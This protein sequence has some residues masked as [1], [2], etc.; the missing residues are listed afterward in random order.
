MSCLIVQADFTLLFE[1]DS[2]KFEEVSEYLSLFSDLV[3]TPEHIHTY[4]ITPLSLWNASASGVK[5][6][7]IIR[8]LKKHSKFEIP[9][10]ICKDI[11]MYMNRY[12]ILR[13]EKNNDSLTLISRDSDIMKR[14]RKSDSIQPY[15]LEEI[16]QYSCRIDL[17]HRGIIKQELIQLGFPVEDIAGY[18]S[19]ETLQ[20]QLSDLELRDYQSNAIESFYQG[21]SKSGG[22]GLIVLPCGSGKT[23]VGMGVMSKVNCETL[24]LTTNMTSVK[25]W[26]REILTKTNV[27]EEFIGEYTGELKQVKPITIA[28]YQIL[29]HRKSKVDEFIHMELF[30]KRDWGLIIYDEVHLLPAPVF[31]ETA[32]IQAT[33]RLGLTATLI[34]EDGREED[35]FSLVG[36]KRFYFPWKK[37]EQQGWISTVKC[38][39]IRVELSA[40]LEKQYNQTENQKQKY[41]LACENSLKIDV[42]E[43]LIGLH[44]GTPTLIIGQYIDQLKKI[45]NILKAPLITGQLPQ[46]E[47]ERLYS[48]FKE[49]KVTLLVV[50]KV[51]NFAIDLPDAGVAIQVSGSFGSRQEEA[52]RLGRVLRPKKTN[53]KAHFYTLITKDTKEQEF[54]LKRQLFLVE[55]G[56]Q[57][58]I[59]D[60]NQITKKELL[61]S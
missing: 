53:N 6:Q 33:R 44:S 31:R 45:S 16:D 26:K 23:I 7:E 58:Q 38:Y 50:S 35:V 3:K 15:L 54:A 41:R 20:I 21:G 17:K 19:G 13:L 40:D 47:R 34:R 28:T 51:A 61:T 59:L 49:G 9:L 29:T 43:Q 30:K 56:Y 46:L 39:E 60:S 36:P 4:K 52:Q 1:T 27:T 24:I 14:I 5:S 32:N 2:P 57:Y 18:L 55:Q 12:G 8:F 22:S 10:K 42:I 48:E 37:L 25:Q 11:Q